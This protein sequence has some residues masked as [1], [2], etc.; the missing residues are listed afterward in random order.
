[1]LYKAFLRQ[2]AKMTEDMNQDGKA[3]NRDILGA[4]HMSLMIVNHPDILH[5][6][7]RKGCDDPLTAA[8]FEDDTVDPDDGNAHSTR[9]GNVYRE[10]Q[11]GMGQDQCGAPAWNG[12]TGVPPE[13]DDGFEV[14]Q[15]LS[16]NNRKKL[17]SDSALKWAEGVFD[18]VSREQGAYEV[19][20][21]ERSGKMM[22]C[23]Q[24]IHRACGN[25]EKV[26]IFSQSVITL[27]V[28][29][30]ILKKSNANAT[31][32]HVSMRRIDGSTPLP[33][34]FDNIK[35]FNEGT[36]NDWVD[37]MLLSTRAGGEGIN[38]TAATRVI[39][40]DVCWNPCH[41]NQAMCRCYRHGQT[42]PVYVYRLVSKG[43]M[44]STIYSQQIH[45]QGLSK[46]VVDDCG[47]EAH[48]DSS[49]LKLFFNIR[50]FKE[51]QKSKNPGV[52]V[53]EDK[54]QSLPY[55]ARGDDILV[56]LCQQMGSTWIDKI[57]PQHDMLKQDK[58]WEMETEEKEAAKTEYEN[59]L[60]GITPAFDYRG[61]GGVPGMGGGAPAFQ[62]KGGQHHGGGQQQPPL[63]QMRLEPAR[64]DAS[65][66]TGPLMP[67]QCR[68][69]LMKRGI[70][71]PDFFKV[72]GTK[73]G[74]MF[75]GAVN[76][77]PPTTHIVSAQSLAWVKNWLRI[78]N[79]PPHM[80]T[81]DIE[82]CLPLPFL[83]SFLARPSSPFLPP[84]ISSFHD[85]SSFIPSVSLPSFLHFTV[86]PFNSFTVFTSFRHFRHFTSVLPAVLYVP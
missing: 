54:D 50:A 57:Y 82:W 10:D 45:K 67:Y 64:N 30:A 20:H 31:N 21:V 2:R 28:I 12:T 8:E 29:E 52:A 58:E 24:M 84:F 78:E 48:Y 71:N 59:I 25:Q 60:K 63:K 13:E 19:N 69:L 32:R 61:G 68:V 51:S 17:P 73:K 49:D 62:M 56:G 39:I 86:L 14:I 42:K 26:L 72:E 47:T 6:A 9:N 65:Y 75:V 83:P 18:G 36:E 1:M 80:A 15:E 46:R 70:K 40:F 37:V 79:F 43:T 11:P 22:V 7:V 44:E 33:K 23:M 27:N 3:S 34:R 38:L 76:M 4:F 74:L 5:A 53:A 16:D 81:H 41:D 66:P 77:R 55:Q 35:D 85:R